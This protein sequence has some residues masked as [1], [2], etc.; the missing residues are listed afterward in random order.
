MFDGKKTGIIKDYFGLFAKIQ[1]SPFSNSNVCIPKNI[2]SE[3]GGYKEGVKLTEDSDL[4]CRI[5]FKYNVAFNITPL[6]NYFLAIDG[7]THT[8]FQEEE[9]QVTK[10]LKEALVNGALEER[11]KSSVK[12]L[13]VFQKMGLIKRSLMSGNKRFVYRHIFDWDLCFYYPKEFF[14]CMLSLIIPY[15]LFNK[16]RKMKFYKF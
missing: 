14:I 12:K 1:K 5:A 2:Y 8:I 7:S 10:T 11:L 15:G 6:A 9:Y 16:L 13:I 4:W 3:F